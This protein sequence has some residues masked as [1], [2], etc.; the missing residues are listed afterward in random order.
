[1]QYILNIMTGLPTVKVDVISFL[2]LPTQYKN[3]DPSSLRPRFLTTKADH[4]SYPSQKMSLLFQY[5]VFLVAILNSYNVIGPNKFHLR[6]HLKQSTAVHP[7]F[8]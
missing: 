4:I 1:M 6:L 3:E 7:M 5:P 2:H 8:E